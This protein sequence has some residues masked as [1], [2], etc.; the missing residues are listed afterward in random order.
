MKYVDSNTTLREKLKNQE[1]MTLLNENNNFPVPD[2][3]IE[4]CDLSDVEFKILV[5]RNFSEL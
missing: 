1:N 3:S 2:P 4:I 5:L